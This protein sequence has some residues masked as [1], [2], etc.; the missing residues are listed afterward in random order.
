MIGMPFHSLTGS[1]AGRREEN[2]SG[3]SV[4]GSD[5]FVG[6]AVWVGVKV[7]TC[8]G[9]AVTVFVGVDVAAGVVIEHPTVR[10]QINVI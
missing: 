1:P 2:V 6:S 4:G 3:V 8:V 10:R 7:G 9:V 5:V